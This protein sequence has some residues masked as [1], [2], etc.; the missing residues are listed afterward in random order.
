VKS[1]AAVELNR[2]CAKVSARHRSAF[3]HAQHRRVAGF[4]GQITVLVKDDGLNRLAVGASR[5]DRE[6]AGQDFDIDAAN[7]GFDRPGYF[8]NAN[9]WAR[10]FALNQ[11]GRE[12]KIALEVNRLQR[13]ADAVFT[14]RTHIKLRR[15]IISA[16]YRGVSRR[17]YGK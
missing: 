15:L 2:Y 16:D 10:I 8:A 5:H 12:R 1:A 17:D 11:R 6:R 13:D 9:R 4:E 14:C 7:S 3:A